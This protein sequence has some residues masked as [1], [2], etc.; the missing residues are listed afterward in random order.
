MDRVGVISVCRNAAD[1]IR[2]KT[3]FYCGHEVVVYVFLQ[4][5]VC[6]FSSR[7]F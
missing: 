6:V 5:H 7:W 2:K 4:V 1:A 3:T